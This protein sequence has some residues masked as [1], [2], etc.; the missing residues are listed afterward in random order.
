MKKTQLVS[1]KGQA[2]LIL[3]LVVLVALGFGLSIISQSVTDVKIS[4]HD[5]EASRAFNAA[6]AGIEQALKDISVA[7]GNLLVDDIQ[8]DYSVTGQTQL[9]GVFKE[10]ESVQ[11]SLTD[12]DP[13]LNTLT[14]E[15]VDS[16]STA[17]NPASCSNASGQAP[18]SLLISIVDDTNQLR[19]LGINSCSLNG[20]NGMVDIAD[21]GSGNFLRQYSFPIDVDGI[22]DDDLLVRIRPIYNTTSLMVTGNVELPVQSYTIDSTAQTP[23]LESKAIKVTRTET[24]TPPIFDYVLFSGTSIVK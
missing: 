7:S 14:V 22:G 12:A 10:N 9:D 19:Q 4:L 24:A 5:Q 11:V 16:T 6:E 20:D 23:S 1:K 21:V 18:A 15:W 13:N 17:E 3:L 2:A 8:V